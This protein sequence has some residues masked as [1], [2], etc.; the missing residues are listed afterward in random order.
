MQWQTPEINLFKAGSF[1]KDGMGSDSALANILLLADKYDT[2]KLVVIPSSVHEMLIIPY[3]G[4]QDIDEF[5]A[6]VKEVNASQVPPEEQ[7][8]DQAYLITV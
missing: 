1:N 8:A 2:D 4:T 6:L 5:S 7:L 3:G